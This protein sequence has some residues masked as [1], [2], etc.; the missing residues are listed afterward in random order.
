VAE[1][2]KGAALPPPP[3]ADLQAGLS[4]SQSSVA[5][6]QA[7]GLDGLEKL[8]GAM[9]AVT[10]RDID[11][12]AQRQGDVRSWLVAACLTAG[13][14][15]MNSGVSFL[16]LCALGG[17]D[18]WQRLPA[19]EI[20]AAIHTAGLHKVKVQCIMEIVGSRLP[21]SD[22]SKIKDPV[23]RSRIEE[24]RAFTPAELERIVE[25]KKV[26][27]YIFGLREKT[28]NCVYLYYAG[29]DNSFVVDINNLTFLV[30][31]GLAKLP[32]KT[33]GRSNNFYPAANG[34]K[35]T[36]SPVGDALKAIED[37]LP[38]MPYRLCYRAVLYMNVYTKMFKR[39][40]EMGFTAP[41]FTN[42][43]E[44]MRTFR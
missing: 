5:R 40:G 37:N 8:V 17:P 29:L 10:G 32:H 41:L 33:D 26:A 1:R 14:N 42:G 34:M 7:L 22:A 16:R 43:R 20:Q 15:D 9:A 44:D 6:L 39:D 24:R 35:W 23:V 19:A 4:R 13:A 31:C 3:A 25:E 27:D 30:D 18:D 28:A 12:P 11:V 36:S 38:D 21:G 2:E